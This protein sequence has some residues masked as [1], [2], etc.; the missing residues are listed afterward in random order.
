MITFLSSVPFPGLLN[1]V[2]LFAI[3][4]I[5]VLPFVPESWLPLLLVDRAD[6]IL[7]A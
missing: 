5:T 2:T 4:K 6:S 1:S 7:L 3:V